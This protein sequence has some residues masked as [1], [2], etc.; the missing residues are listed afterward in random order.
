[1]TQNNTWLQDS[2]EHEDNFNI[3]KNIYCNEIRTTR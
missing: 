2:K 1:M 3:N